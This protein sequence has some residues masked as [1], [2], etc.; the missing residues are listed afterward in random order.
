MKKVFLASLFEMFCLAAFSQTLPFKNEGGIE[1]HRT[2]LV[3]QWE[4]PKNSWPETLWVYRMVPTK[5]SKAAVSYLMGIGSFREKDRTDCGANKICFV[6]Q[7]GSRLHINLATGQIDYS[8]SQSDSTNRVPNVP[9]TSQLLSLATN[10]LIHVGIDLSEV[11]RRE[12]G[13]LRIGLFNNIGSSYTENGATVTN[14]T[15]RQVWIARAVDG[16]EFSFD[17]GEVELGERGR[18]VKIWLKWR[19]LKREKSYPAATPD[20]FIKWMREGRAFQKRFA[21]PGSEE[22]AFDWATIKRV[23]VKKVKALYTSDFTP[24]S[25]E[26]DSS[27]WVKPYAN[28]W[29]TVDT[30]VTN[31]DVQIVCP[32][33]NETVSVKN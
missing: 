15:A 29:A 17:G 12:N 11:E 5:Y 7:N 13:E 24:L 30:G 27:S 14:I 32:I 22:K 2:N 26:P 21:G 18:V 20:L 8:P 28:L 9:D 3:V 6:S 16:V 23:T 31:I 19:S 4:A 33:I 1:F 25:H 10:F